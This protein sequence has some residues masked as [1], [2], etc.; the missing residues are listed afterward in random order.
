MSSLDD[1]DIPVW[2]LTVPGLP[3]R[4]LYPIE[5]EAPIVAAFEGTNREAWI[6]VTPTAIATASLTAL[7]EAGWRLLPPANEPAETAS[8][9]NASRSTPQ[10]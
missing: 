10:G 6:N 5:A 9:E 7:R 2:R 1:K 4:P 3:E 8:T